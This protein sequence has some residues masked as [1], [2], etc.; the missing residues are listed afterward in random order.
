ML[1]PEIEKHTPN[2]YNML[3]LPL[4]CDKCFNCCVSRIITNG[5]LPREGGKR[6]ASPASAGGPACPTPPPSAGSPFLPASEADLRSIFGFD[7]LPPSA[8]ADQQGGGEGAYP[9]LPKRKPFTAG[10][11]SPAATP[12]S[13]L[14]SPGSTVSRKPPRSKHE[15]ATA[16]RP[17]Q[18]AHSRLLIGT[19]MLKSPVSKSQGVNANVDVLELE[20]LQ[21]EKQQQ[22]ERVTG[23]RQ[24]LNDLESTENEEIG[25]LDFERSLLVGELDAEND[26]IRKVSICNIFD[27]SR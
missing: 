21:V 5:S 12:T 13:P 6:H 15:G 14:T 17:S 27:M 2:L 3:L 22:L 4:F 1:Q 19:T 25:E 24:R 18:E 7:S 10:P 8:A 9:A 16:A 11:L 23:L 26:K 20:R